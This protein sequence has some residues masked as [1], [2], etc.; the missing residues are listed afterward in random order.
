VKCSPDAS[1]FDA[2]CAYEVGCGPIAI[3]VKAKRIRNLQGICK[4]RTYNYLTWKP[5]PGI[6]VDRADIPVAI[7]KTA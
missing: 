1:L 4:K 7:K 3:K 5:P 2:I 6:M